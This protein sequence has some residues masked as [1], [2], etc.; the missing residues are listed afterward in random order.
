MCGIVGLLYQHVEKIQPELLIRMRDVLQHR[1]PDGAGLWLSDHQQVG[2]GHRRLAII[3][4]GQQA[5][6]PMISSD[7]QIVLCFNGEIY[8]HQALRRQLQQQGYHDWHTD[9]S[10]TEVLLNAYRAWGQDCL[11][12]L[13]GMF[14]FAIWDA[15]QQILFCARDRLGIK[16]FYFRYQAGKFIFASEIKAILE[17]PEVSR[18]VNETALYHYL[19]FLTAPAPDTLFATIQKLPAGHRLTIP[20][21][22]PLR[23]ERYWDVY[24]DWRNLSSVPENEIVEQIRTSLRDAVHCHKIADVP[25]GVFLSGGIDSSTNAAL[26]AENDTHIHT[27]S[28]GYEGQYRSYQNELH[29]AKQMADSIQANYHERLLNQTDLIDF[30]PKLIHLQDEPIADPVCFPV[31]AVAELAR[32]HGVVVCQVGEGADELFWGYPSWKTKLRLQ[33]LNQIKGLRSLKM[34]LHKGLSYTPY[35]NSWSQEMLNRGLQQQP[36][37]WGG[38]EAF[39]DTQKR[40]LLSQTYQQ[41]LKGLTS[42]EAI[43]PIYQNFKKNAPDPHWLNWMSYCDLHYRLPELLLMRVD[44]MTMGVSLESRVP[45]L[46]HHFVSLA[47]SIPATL[48]TR[49]GELKYLL[50]QAVRGLIPDAIIDRPKQGFGVPVYEWFFDQLGI[51]I[52][53][54]LTQFCHDTDYFDANAIT[55]YLNSGHGGQIWYLFNLALWWNYYIAKR[56]I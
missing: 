9:H 43:E 17:H 2:F 18:E 35:R 4:P 36:L 13:R 26:F 7:R 39:T 50:K 8:N 3:N 21:N 41:R 1:G 54:T 40:Q 34:L 25:L 31:Y 6:Q 15:Q 19:S 5:N 48:K 37:F 47:M 30:L 42:W 52:K 55:H 53:Q 23:I 51:K 56:P 11:Q 45:F 44:K 10:D 29:Y 32:Q 12:Q 20:L 14:A 22:G 28:I 16:P 49:H 24:D 46:D 27:F 38:A 33:Q